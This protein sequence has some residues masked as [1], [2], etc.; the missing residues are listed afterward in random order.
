MSGLATADDALAFVE[1]QGVVLVSAKGSGPSL[2]E[3]IVGLP[4]RGSWWGHAQGKRIFALLS[5]VTDSEHVLVCRLIDGKLT[6]VHRRLWPPLIRV[7]HRV[8]VERLARVSQEHPAS[9]RHANHE[10]AFP[11]WVP[12]AVAEAAQALDEQESLATL[13]AWLSFATQPSSTIRKKS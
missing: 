6:L 4:V 3:A 12:A 5:A 1:A 11:R 7:A 10:I 9:G 2:V 13:G 8:G